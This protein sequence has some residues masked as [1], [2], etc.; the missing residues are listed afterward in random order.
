MG[1]E[2]YETVETT[3]TKKSSGIAW[4]RTKSG[5]GKRKE[6]ENRTDCIDI[7]TYNTA[8]EDIKRLLQEKEADP[9]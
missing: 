5:E 6:T 8:P 9:G 7:Y 4:S 3:E 2:H 1:I